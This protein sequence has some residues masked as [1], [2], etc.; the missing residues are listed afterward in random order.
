MKNTQKA[1]WPLGSVLLLAGTVILMPSNIGAQVPVTLDD[2]IARALVRSPTMAQQDQSVRTAELSRRTA[3][4]SFMPSV[5]ASSSGSLRSTS[6]FDPNTDRIV[7]GSADSY[8][9]GLSASYTL[10]QGGRRFA[11]MDVAGADIAAAQARR[12]NQR[13]QVI[14]QAKSSFFLAL[15][16]GDLL[17]VARQRVDQAQQTLELVRT[18]TRLG[19]ATLS[20]SLRARLDVANAQQAQLQTETAL[21]AAQFALGRLI[22]E[23]A[24]VVPERPAMLEPTELGLTDEEIYILAEEESPSVTAAREAVTAASAGVRS[25]KTAWFPSFSLSSGYNWANQDAS[26]SGGTAS[27]SLGLRA[28]YPI[29]NGFQRESSIDRAQLAQRV[30]RLQQDDALLAARQE[31]DAAL[32]DL[33]A[34]ERAIEIALEADLVA[35]EDLRVV[36]ERYRLSVATILDL[37]VSQIS[38]AQAAADVVTSR[39]DYLLARA[40]LEAVLGREL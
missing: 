2:A 11:D 3:W 36:R 24:P 40:Q 12:Q 29:F 31:A 9:A 15:R 26:L 37:V 23:R 27:W 14:L 7:E 32:W 28:S 33:R 16:Q 1:T 6:R 13:F 17:E 5:S 39:Y 38:A 20:D 22:G 21:R 34:A 18:Q 30:A 19:T 4:G 10:F 8:S 35:Q 25:A